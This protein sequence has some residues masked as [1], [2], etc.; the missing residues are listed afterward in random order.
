MVFPN[1]QLGFEDRCSGENLAGSKAIKID[2]HNMGQVALGSIAELN[3]ARLSLRIFIRPKIQAELGGLEGAH[4]FLM[5]AA[6][7][8]VKIIISFAHVS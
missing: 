4:A 3:S 8:S 5:D 7:A 2:A 1:S 6:A